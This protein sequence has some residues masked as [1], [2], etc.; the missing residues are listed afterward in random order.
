MAVTAITDLIIPLELKN[1]TQIDLAKLLDFQLRGAAVRQPTGPGEF[2]DIR[3]FNALTGDDDV[4]TDAATYD[5]NSVTQHKDTAVICHRIKNFGA[6]DLSQ[7]V[8]GADPMG[9]ISRQISH[10]FANAMST[11]MLNVLTAIFGSSGPLET[12]NKHDVYSNS[13][14]IYLTPAVAAVGLQHIGDEMN[15]L[16]VIFMHSATY[17]QL[18]AAGYLET[19]H[20]LSAYGIAQDGSVSSFMGRPI[21]VSDK[22]TYSTAGGG[23]YPNSAKTFFVGMGALT[24]GI[25]Q[26]VNPE[27]GRDIK[28]K[29]DYI[30]TDVHF[31]PHVNGVRWSSATTNPTNAQLATAT[32]WALAYSN[33]K[34]VKVVCIN[35]NC[36][37]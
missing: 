7:I 30:A 14:P 36:P 8:S 25:Q 9:A 6:S 27:I 12:S 28:N 24:Y 21:V 4:M 13:A 31:T 20:N 34:F 3:G 33:A 17:A 29:I 1:R 35:H 22:C 32:N 18:L 5:V 11:A 16:G 15:S 23:S 37:N 26:D 19:N 10:Y 2:V